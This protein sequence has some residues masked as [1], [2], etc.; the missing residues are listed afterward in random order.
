MRLELKHVAP[1]LPYE[2]KCDISKRVGIYELQGTDN[3]YSATLS[4]GAMGRNVTHVLHEIKPMLRPLSDLEKEIKHEGET[5]QIQEV[6]W[7]KNNDQTWQ[8]WNNQS[9]DKIKNFR[10]TIEEATKLFEW[11]FDVFGL[12]PAGQAI[13]INTLNK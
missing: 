7:G 3:T 9:G 2:L 8:I 12:I 1:Y 5:I 11:H 10:F 4:K 13:D 6:M